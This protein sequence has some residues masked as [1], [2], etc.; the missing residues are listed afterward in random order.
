M[1]LLTFCSFKDFMKKKSSSRPKSIKV[2]VI[3]LK[4]KQICR[5]LSK[6][7]GICFLAST[8]RKHAL[9]KEISPY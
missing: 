9:P 5:I 3:Q 7:I 8:L 1:N 4:I 6:S 2:W